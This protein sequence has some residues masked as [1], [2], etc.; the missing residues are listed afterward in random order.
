[1][2]V[3][4]LGILERGAS[5]GAGITGLGLNQ[6]GGLLRR[7]DNDAMAACEIELLD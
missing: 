3:N 2:V 7:A 6:I 1:M 4:K 5:L